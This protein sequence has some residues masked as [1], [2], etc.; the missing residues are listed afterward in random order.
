MKFK[1][2]YTL[3]SLIVLLFIFKASIY[4]AII[5]YEVVGSRKGYEVKDENLINFIEKELIEDDLID[6][7]SILKKSR[8]LTNEKLHFTSSKCD[9]DPNK[10][11]TSE[12]THCIGYALF[13]ETIC[14]YMIK[15]NPLLKD[16]KATT[17]I[18]ELYFFGINIH[19][20]IESPFFKDHDFVIIENAKTGQ[21]FFIDPTVSDYL[22]IDTVS[23]R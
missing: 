9:I 7:E 21:K 1:K 10:L 15:K 20:Y 12:Y 16:W 19:N 11:I 13:F 14:N 17:R 8:V 5:K 18:G 2:I 6:I 22:S 23:I 4:R 3:S